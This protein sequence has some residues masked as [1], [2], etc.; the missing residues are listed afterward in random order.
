MTLH[1]AS[2]WP[3]RDDF[4]REAMKKEKWVKEFLGQLLQLGCTMSDGDHMMDHS[5]SLC[6]R[7]CNCGKLPITKRWS[8]LDWSLGL[9]SIP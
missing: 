2:I 9:E 4:K 6:A 7:K 8:K 1:G 5:Y 3:Y